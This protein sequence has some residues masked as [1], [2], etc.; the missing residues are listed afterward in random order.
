VN[1]SGLEDEHVRS[2]GEELSRPLVSV[3]PEGSTLAAA[4]GPC[5]DLT[6]AAVS[7]CLRVE[8][9]GGCSASIGSMCCY[10][11]D[12]GRQHVTVIPRAICD[13]RLGSRRRACQRSSTTV[14]PG[15]GPVASP[16]P[17]PCQS[18]AAAVGSR[19]LASPRFVP[20]VAPVAFLTLSKSHPPRSDYYSLPY[21][22]FLPPT[23]ASTLHASYSC[24]IK[25]LYSLPSSDAPAPRWP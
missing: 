21:L 20:L 8:R 24:A 10:Y 12:D 5:D 9:V 18:S 15:A 25:H 1:S 19:I 4:P 22:I 23:N 14:Q 16:A 6:G 13:A 11:D 2:K 3:T 17:V 7:P